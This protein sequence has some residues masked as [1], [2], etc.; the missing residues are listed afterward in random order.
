MRL[1]NAGG[2]L[3]LVTDGGIVDV[4]SASQGIFS[5][6][7]QAVYERWAEFSEWSMSGVDGSA[8]AVQEKDIGPPVPRPTQIFGL[9]LNYRDHAAEAHAQ[10][11]AD[12]PVVFTKFSSS[13]TGPFATVELPRGSVDYEA[14]LVVVLGRHTHRVP[15]ERAWEHVA[16]L[17]VGQDL[18]ERELQLTGAVPQLNLGKSYPGFAPLGPE[19][20]T[21]DEL[22]NP[23]DL[24]IS[25]LLNGEQRQKA[26]TSALILPVAGIIA[27][28]SSILPLLPGDLIFTGTPAGV[29]WARDP[30]QLL[31]PGDELATHVEGIGTMRNHF[32]AADLN[33]S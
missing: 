2:R 31:S 3:G 30:K 5:P 19:L 28:L 15:A 12:A 14:E 18:S 29:G 10:T 6:D 22:N 26:R 24:E 21:P 25:C 20:V 9:G 17:T 27:Y 13:V 23:D 8:R 4:A 7:V 16:G 32:T 33:G 11:S 1:V